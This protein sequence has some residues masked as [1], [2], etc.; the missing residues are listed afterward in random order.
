M[1][2]MRLNDPITQPRWVWL[3]LCLTMMVFALICLD[4]AVR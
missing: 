2:R 3:S 4:K 1:K